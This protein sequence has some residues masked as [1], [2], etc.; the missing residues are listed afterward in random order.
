MSI[1][2]KNPTKSEV[3]FRLGST[4]LFHYLHGRAKDGPF[5]EDKIQ[6]DTTFHR[7][8]RKFLA[9]SGATVFNNLTIL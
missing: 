5:G 4:S 6:H 7:L 2:L 9:F 8:G 1:E 3:D